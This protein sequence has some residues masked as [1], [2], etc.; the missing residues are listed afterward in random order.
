MTDVSELPDD[1]AD[2]PDAGEDLPGLRVLM[3]IR[4]PYHEHGGVERVVRDVT[5]ELR[6]QH[7]TWSVEP[8]PAFTGAHRLEGLDGISDVI[9]SLRL[10]YRLRRTPAD[11]V[12]VHCPEC[13]WGLR[14]FGVTRRV[15]VVVVWHG[16]GAKP[17]LVLR[18]SGNLLARALAAFRTAEER[19]ALTGT[20]QVAV[21]DMVRRDLASEYGFHGPVTVIENALDA[22]TMERLAAP[23]ASRAGEPLTA[24]WV[25]QAGHRKGLD[26]AIAA[27]R[28]AREKVPEI[29][30]VV[31]GVPAGDPEP[32]VEWRGIVDPSEIPDVY[33][34]ADVLLFPTRYESFGLVLVEAMAAG[35]PVITSDAVPEGI[36]AQDVNGW[37]VEGHEPEPYA[38]AL[39]RL[40]ED[41]GLRER[42]GEVNR[43]EAARFSLASAA[44]RYAEVARGVVRRGRG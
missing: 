44:R 1:T 2:V 30:L 32:G 43:R 13:V 5:H 17:Y 42:L 10:G 18:S 7:P 21:H 25:G 14:L 24:V 19:R 31:A 23:R 4:R 29:R 15:P 34:A 20:E 35:L 36:V 33:H 16:A 9:A 41:P 11:V 12:F 39:V 28:L 22:G 27:V 8:L 37:V 26:V 38:E 6:R 40:A 3:A